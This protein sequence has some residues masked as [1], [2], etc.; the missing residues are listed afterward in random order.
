MTAFWVLSRHTTGRRIAAP[1][2]LRTFT[3][4]P[5]WRRGTAPTANERAATRWSMS[6]GQTASI[7]SGTGVPTADTIRRAA[8]T[9]KPTASEAVSAPN[10]ATPT[11]AAEAVV[12]AETSVTTARPVPHGAAATGMNTAVP[13]A[14]WWTTAPATA[15]TFTARGSITAAASFSGIRRS[16]RSFPPAAASTGAATPAPTAAREPIA[17]LPIRFQRSTRSTAQPST[18]PCNPAPSAMRRSPRPIP[19]IPS[20]TEAGRAIL[21]RST[22]GPRPAPPADTASMNTPP[23]P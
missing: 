13:A 21:P 12:E 11:A 16:G 6:S 19:P 7:A 20:P 5:C 1:P 3:A 9:A 15:P 14:H 2:T 4:S 17:T 18:E 23:I 10:A 8:S 22:A